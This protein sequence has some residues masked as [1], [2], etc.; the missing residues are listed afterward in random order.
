MYKKNRGDP[1]DLES[2]IKGGDQGKFKAILVQNIFWFWKYNPTLQLNPLPLIIPQS[3]EGL[4][5]NP[6]W[7]CKRGYTVDDN[8]K[9]TDNLD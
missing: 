2:K 7:G 5:N 1:Y 8:G 9:S 4:K 6:P 3:A